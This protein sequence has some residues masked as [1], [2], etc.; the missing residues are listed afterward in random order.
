[1]IS[2]TICGESYVGETG[3]SMRL[4]YLE[5]RG[6][7]NAAPTS[8]AKQ[9]CVRETLTHRAASGKICQLPIEDPF[10]A[11]MS[12]DVMSKVSMKPFVPLNS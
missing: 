7:S 12:F 8:V 1:M 2:P 4:A 10:G 3:K 9:K 6:D 11:G 5:D